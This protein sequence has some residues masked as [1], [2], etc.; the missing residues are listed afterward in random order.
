MQGQWNSQ[1]QNL[2]LPPKL[3]PNKSL[4][5]KKKMT[6]YRLLTRQD[7]VKEKKELEQKK[8]DKIKLKER[9]EKGEEKMKAW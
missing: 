9:E 3:S 4:S 8:K 5:A 6:G 7:I 1:I 2:F